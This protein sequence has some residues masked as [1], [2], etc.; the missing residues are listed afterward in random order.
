M[1]RTQFQEMRI[2]CSLI[3]HLYHPISWF[4]ASIA[5]SV[6]EPYASA[7][8]LP[9]DS[10]KEDHGCACRVFEV[11]PL[12]DRGT[13]RRR[14]GWNFSQLFR[15]LDHVPEITCMKPREFSS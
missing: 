2:G 13:Y 5:L 6:N 8:S 3:G 1:Q 7:V 4:K 15:F 14:D 10:L 9:C 11:E 12:E